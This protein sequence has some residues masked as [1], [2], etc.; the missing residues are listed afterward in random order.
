MKELR[1]FFF[2]YYLHY[3]TFVYHAV[4]ILKQ[5]YPLE[6]CVEYLCDHYVRRTYMY[7]SIIVQWWPMCLYYIHIP[8]YNNITSYYKIV[9][10]IIFWGPSEIT[11]EI[12]S[13]QF[14]SRTMYRVL[15]CYWSMII[16]FITGT[17]DKK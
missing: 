2:Y 13:C 10:L 3:E 4:A 7:D 11:L 17:R 9:Y 6:M 14:S 15:V 16:D 12:Y 1:T 5:S 8:I